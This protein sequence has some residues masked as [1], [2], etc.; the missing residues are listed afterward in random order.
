MG[1]G[2]KRMRTTAPKR[3]ILLVPDGQWRAKEK[4]LKVNN[5]KSTCSAP[6]LRAS[7]YSSALN[8]KATPL[9][10]VPA[11]PPLITAIDTVIIV[12]GF[13]GKVPVILKAPNSTNGKEG[14]FAFSTSSGD[15]RKTVVRCHEEKLQL[16]HQVKAHHSACAIL[17]LHKTAKRERIV[18]K[19]S[20]YNSVIKFILPEQTNKCETD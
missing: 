4:P 19:F 10:W 5:F 8:S 3:I 16:H 13:F 2:S 14:H 7:L 18:Y 1:L 15:V 17:A 20:R 11:E 12:Q 6:P 9:S